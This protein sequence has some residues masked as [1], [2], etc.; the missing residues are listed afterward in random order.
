[1]GDAFVPPSASRQLCPVVE[2]SRLETLARALQV[3]SPSLAHPPWPLGSLVLRTSLG[4]S[5]LHL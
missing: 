5:E 4:R 3:A 1:M 2:D